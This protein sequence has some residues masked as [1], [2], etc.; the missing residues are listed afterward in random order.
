MLVND[1]TTGF[2]TIL[3][4]KSFGDLT[5]VGA[6]VRVREDNVSGKAAGYRTMGLGAGGTAVGGTL[7]GAD[8]DDEDLYVLSLL[9]K[10]QNVNYQ[11]TSAYFYGGKD[12]LISVFGDGTRGVTDG[13]ATSTRAF[14]MKSPSLRKVNHVVWSIFFDL[15]F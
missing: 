15:K 11:L 2:A 8:R 5:L 7:S 10:F 6:D 4:S 13:R 9:G 12:G 3:L 1:D 14:F